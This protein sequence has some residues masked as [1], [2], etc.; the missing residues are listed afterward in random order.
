MLARQT[1][2]NTFIVKEL[3]KTGEY[4]NSDEAY[5]LHKLNQDALKRLKEEWNAK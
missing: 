2:A 5:L 3:M 1:Q 4:R